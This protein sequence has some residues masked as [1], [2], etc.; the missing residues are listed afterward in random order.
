[1]NYADKIKNRENFVMENV[2]KKEKK[3]L[4][5]VLFNNQGKLAEEVRTII[6]RT[7]KYDIRKEYNTNK[8]PPSGNKIEISTKYPDDGYF[9]VYSMSGELPDKNSFIVY[10]VNKSEIINPKLTV[11]VENNTA[12]LVENKEE[13]EVVEP[14][15]VVGTIV[16]QLQENG[17]VYIDNVD[18]H[19]KCR[20]LGICGLMFYYMS[21]ITSVLNPSYMYLNIM[22]AN[23]D[24]ACKCYIKNLYKD[25]KYL[26]IEYSNKG[27]SEKKEKPVFE[28][29]RN[30]VCDN[31]HVYY[32]YYFKTQDKL[33]EWLLNKK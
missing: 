23:S 9:Y 20:N 32:I 10:C 18:S 30:I 1:M 33:N 12:S 14:D 27:D 6:E 13:N 3:Y 4:L 11:L 25:W 8:D 29:E 15:S 16:V 21:Y 7:K 19:I 26:Y 28:E 2:E 31:N 22:S 5:Y 24:S 17:V